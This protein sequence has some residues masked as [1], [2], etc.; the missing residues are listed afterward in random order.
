MYTHVRSDVS[1]TLYDTLQTLKL[2]CDCLG[3]L[4]KIRILRVFL[5]VTQTCKTQI[6]VLFYSY[7]SLQRVHR[8]SN[9]DSVS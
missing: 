6:T 5:L 2:P 9:D 7:S 3:Y 4:P 1:A 8:Y